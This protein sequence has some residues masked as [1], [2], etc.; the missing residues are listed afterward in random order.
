M[1]P[2]PLDSK[3]CMGAKIPCSTS[4]GPTRGASGTDESG[5]DQMACHST[6]CVHLYDTCSA[7]S[8]YLSGLSQLI[9]RSLRPWSLTEKDFDH[10]PCYTGWCGILDWR[11]AAMGAGHQTRRRITA[12]YGRRIRGQGLET[13]SGAL[14]TYSDPKGDAASTECMPAAI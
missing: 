10:R 8:V 3:T 11:I 13:S 1:H 6:P 5:S 7:Q 2:D 4:C 14:C 12:H 9:L